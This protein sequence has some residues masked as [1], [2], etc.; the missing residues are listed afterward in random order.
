MP[1]AVT[2]MF[3]GVVEA[4]VGGSSTRHMREPRLL[5]LGATMPAYAWPRKCTVTLVPAVCPHP[6]RAARA[7]ALW[8]TTLSL[9]VGWRLIVLLGS[10]GGGGRGEGGAGTV[11]LV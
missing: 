4:G 7:G 10:G 6:K 1:S 9:S 2:L 11:A 8:S 3:S 5:P